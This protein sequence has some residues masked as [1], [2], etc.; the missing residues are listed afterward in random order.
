MGGGS[1]S[2]CRKKTHKK[3][4]TLLVLVP[5]I[6]G[7][8]GLIFKLPFYLLVCVCGRLSPRSKRGA[9][10]QGRRRKGEC[11]RPRCWPGLAQLQQRATSSSFSPLR[12]P[13]HADFL[14]KGDTQSLPE[15]RR[16]DEHGQPTAQAATYSPH[17]H[18]A[19][20][21]RRRRRPCPADVIE[22]QTTVSLSSLSF[23]PFSSA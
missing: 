22:C 5:C 12:S 18:A 14:I 20:Q 4:Y 13:C 21:R 19:A 8:L 23:T 9:L 16:F 17:H 11:I 10:R 6:R 1:Y 2:V 15:G 3:P 7:C